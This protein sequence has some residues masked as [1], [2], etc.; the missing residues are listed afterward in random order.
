MAIGYF[1][2][3]SYT[4]WQAQTDSDIAGNQVPPDRQHYGVPDCPISKDCHISGTATDVNE[5]YTKICFPFSQYSLTC[6]AN[7]V[8]HNISMAW[9]DGYKSFTIF[10]IDVTTSNANVRGSYI[11]S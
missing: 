11:L 7:V 8:L 2:F 10:R 9:R 3:L 5:R 1:K 6:T 4:E